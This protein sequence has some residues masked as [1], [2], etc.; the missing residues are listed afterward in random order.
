M[1]M[2]NSRVIHS[3]YSSRVAPLSQGGGDNMNVSVFDVA[4]FILKTKGEMTTLKL[5]KLCFY[6]QSWHLALV[7]EKLFD[8]DF[9]AWAN[10]PVSPELFDAHRAKFLVSEASFT[11]GDAE[12]IQGESRSIALEVLE[13]YGELT[14]QELSLLSHRE[15]PW[16]K[17]RNGLPAGAIC[18]EV[19]PPE[20]M[21][22]QCRDL[23]NK[24]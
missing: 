24:S 13:K 10:G 6:I 23:L 17:S 18:V 16:L 14:P 15:D 1:E 22:A 12:K 20:L 8:G 9:Q 11:V 21:A 4:Q 5:Q 7:G 3:R 2:K 19:I